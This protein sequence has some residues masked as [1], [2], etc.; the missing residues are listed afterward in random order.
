MINISNKNISFARAVDLKKS[1]MCMQWKNKRN[2]YQAEE[3]EQH[4]AVE[5]CN[6]SF[7][8]RVETLEFFRHVYIFLRLYE[9]YIFPRLYEVPE[10]CQP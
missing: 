10:M 7:R 3:E 1:P 8:G 9:V 6:D 4:E 2:E 5:D